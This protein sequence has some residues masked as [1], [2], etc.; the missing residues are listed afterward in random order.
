MENFVRHA[1]FA[2]TSVAMDAKSRSGLEYGGGLDGF[3][4]VPDLY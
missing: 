3:L 4:P 2:L 1:R